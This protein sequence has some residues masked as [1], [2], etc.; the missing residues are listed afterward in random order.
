MDSVNRLRAVEDP[1][2]GAEILA[3]VPLRYDEGADPGQDRPSHVRS[4]SGIS[5]IG[6]RLAVF[7]DDAHFLAL[8]NPADLSVRALALPRGPGGLRQFDDL[9]GNKASKLDLEANLVVQLNG[10]ELL[11]AFGSGSTPARDMV[12]VVNVRRNTAVLRNAA[13]LYAELRA[14]TEFCGSELNVEGALL[15]HGVVRLFN[16]GNGAPRNGLH[17]VDA[18]ADLDGPALWKYLD[19]PQSAAVPKLSNVVQYELGALQ[20]IRLTFTDACVAGERM[21]F[22]AAAEDS[23]DVT[24]DG[25]VGGSALG[26]IEDSRTVSYGI[27]RDENGSVFR[28]KI[29]GVTI[30][31]AEPNQLYVVVDTDDPTAASELCVVRL[32]EE[33]HIEPES[34]SGLRADGRRE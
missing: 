21:L 10:E 4:A 13:G 28:G 12:A 30:S 17:P 25:W 9:R 26:L 6:D 34:Y 5:W 23:P 20:G 31:R 33:W 7:Q 19:N 29:E 15:T 11:I 24:R 16:R 8:V 1:T 14:R 32:S 3:R 27:L 22:A 18:T 2:L